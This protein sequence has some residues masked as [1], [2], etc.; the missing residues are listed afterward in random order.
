M[1]RLLQAFLQAIIPLCA[2]DGGGGK[3]E[4]KRRREKNAKSQKTINGKY[5]HWKL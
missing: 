5:N 3:R 4:R 2:C 1:R